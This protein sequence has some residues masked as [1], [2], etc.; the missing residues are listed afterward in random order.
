MVSFLHILEYKFTTTTGNI[1][2]EASFICTDIPVIFISP[3]HAHISCKFIWIEETISIHIMFY[4]IHSRLI[5]FEP[6]TDLIPVSDIKEV[7]GLIPEVLY[8]RTLWCDRTIVICNR[9]IEVLFPW[10]ITTY[11]I[12]CRCSALYLCT[13]LIWVRSITIP[14]ECNTLC[15]I[16]CKSRILTCLQIIIW[17]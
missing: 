1:H 7:E 15:G 4:I 14:L 9:H 17:F 13:A 16:H 11:C 12:W 6:R 5:C 10:Y 3:V 8:L 2:S